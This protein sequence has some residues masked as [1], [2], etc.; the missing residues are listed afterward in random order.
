MLPE[1]AS[2]KQSMEKKGENEEQS[3]EERQL[4]KSSVSEFHFSVLPPTELVLDSLLPSTEA[5]FFEKYSI[6]SFLGDGATC[7]VRYVSWEI[8]I[9]SG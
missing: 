6:S 4:L 8:L 1:R 9:F 3:E 2:L 7:T 5:D